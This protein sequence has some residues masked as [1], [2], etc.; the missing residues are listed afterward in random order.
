[1]GRPRRIDRVERSHWRKQI[2]ENPQGHWPLATLSSVWPEPPEPPP[3]ELMYYRMDGTPCAGPSLVS[4][5]AQQMAGHIT[6]SAA[7][8]A[9]SMLANGDAISTV[10]LGFGLAGN[11]L[12]LFETYVVAGPHEGFRWQYI[13]V[14]RARQGHAHIVALAGIKE[15]VAYTWRRGIYRGRPVG[16]LTEDSAIGELLGDCASCDVPVGST[17]GHVI[18]GRPF[19]DPEC[20]EDW[21]HADHGLLYCAGCL[22][23]CEAGVVDQGIGPYEYW[24]SQGVDVALAAVSQCCEDSVHRTP[25]CDGPMLDP[26]DVGESY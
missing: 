24:G 17:T 1:M 4:R 25:A 20:L 6:S 11:H 7:R 3:G 2:A 15:T 9:F 19:C 13:N 21:T 26:H 10:L 5:W 16:G 22:E 23:E 18:A 14:D 8:V 12:A